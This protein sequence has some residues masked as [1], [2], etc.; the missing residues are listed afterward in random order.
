MGLATRAGA[1][2]AVPSAWLR[3]LP[4]VCASA[5]LLGGLVVTFCGALRLAHSNSAAAAL[6]FQGLA[7]RASDEV[8]HRMGAFEQA[9]RGARGLIVA[10]GPE[11]ITSLVFHQYSETQD[12]TH[13]LPGTIG[14]GVLRRPGRTTPASRDQRYAVQFFEPQV[15]NSEA[16]FGAAVDG[17]L[18]EAAE[19]SMQTGRATLSGPTVGPSGNR[20]PRY[21]MSLIL[22][23][24]GPINVAAEGID[25]SRSNGELRAS[26]WV[27]VPL[28]IDSVLTGLDL[29]AGEISLELRDVTAADAAVLFVSPAGT[30]QAANG[31][32][33]R[34]PLR[35][36]GRTWETFVRAQ[37]PLLAALGQRDP[38]REMTRGI[39]LSAILA[40][41]MWFGVRRNIRRNAESARRV[42]MALAAGAA[43]MHNATLERKVNERTAGLEMAR[44]DLRMILDSMP[45]M[46]SYWDKDLVNVFTNRANEN[47]FGAK[48]GTLRGQHLH[49]LLGEESFARDLPH[50]EAALRGEA[51]SFE[52]SVSKLTGTGF[53]YSVTDYI[54]DVDIGVVRGFYVLTYDVSELVEGRLQLA[55]ALR[56]NEELLRTLDLHAKVSITDEKGFITYVNENFCRILGYRRDEVL[57]RPHSI[58][59]SGVQS[60][61]FWTGMWDTISTGKPWR[62]EICNRSKDGALHWVDAIIAPF[63]GKDGRVQKYV[64]IGTNI[65]ASKAIEHKLRSNEAFL[66]RIG[67][68]AGIGGWEF[69]LETRKVTWSAQM[70]RL[71]EVDPAY[72][73]CSETETA[74]YAIEAQPLI[75]S[76]IAECVE[77]GVAWDFEV[78]AATAKGRPIWVRS[79]GEPEW[80]QGR[81]VRVIG[82]VQDVTARRELTQGIS[83]AESANRA[84]SQ[85]LA[86]MSHEIRTPMNAVMGLSYLLSHTPLTADQSILLAKIQVASNSLLSVITNILDLSKIEANEL[87]VESTVFSVA[88]L[89][90][91]VGIMMEVHA[92]AKDLDFA[93]DIPNDLPEALAG[94]PTRLKQILVNLLSNAIRFTDEGSVRFRT[95]WRANAQAEVILSFSVVDTGIGISPAEQTKI[96]TPFTQ[97]DTSITRRYGGTGL[98]L[99]IVRQLTQLLRGTVEL[100]SIVGIGSTFAVDIPFQLASRGALMALQEAAAV[101]EPGALRGIRVLIVDD[102]AINLEVAKRILELDGALV[103]LAVNGQQAFERLQQDPGAFDVVFMDVQMPILDGY[104]ATRRIRGELGLLNLPIIAVTAGALSSERNRAE[105]A[106]MDDFI[107]KPFSG[108]TLAGSILSHVPAATVRRASHHGENANVPQ[109]TQVPWPEIEGIDAADASVRWCGD[110]SLFITMLARLFDEFGTIRFPRDVEVAGETTQFV[111]QMHK[112]RGG[113]CMLGAKTVH[114]LAGEVEAACLSG[115]FTRAAELSRRVASEIL[116]LGTN[117]RPVIAAERLRAD[118]SLLTATVPVA[119]FLF[120]ELDALL[121]KQS[122]AAVDSFRSLSPQ[123]RQSMG[124]AL[125][126]RMRT[127]ID[128]LQFEEASDLL[129]STQRQPGPM[130]DY[131]AAPMSVAS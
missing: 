111:R 80:Q 69:D 29:G 37:P 12:F 122:L 17:G 40:C 96:F 6:R 74:F 109:V 34:Q 14:I 33:L 118:N 51:R 43:S 107:C 84:K 35:L 116:R 25:H 50:I 62:G 105:D 61:E 38:L 117:A 32:E 44:N 93:M 78:P 52:Q 27:F 79:I 83:K 4:T 67:S 129:E 26:S 85:F 73:P 9:L 60:R 125:Y 99:S 88:D 31:L 127:H 63:L 112:L 53:R 47:W 92:E 21:G 126:E 45:A 54:P 22:P 8:A 97:A 70:H 101:P 65:S 89:L 98:G 49:A 81:V 68:V 23:I 128:N 48:P 15:A 86:N 77:H 108:Q 3:R 131:E 115:D 59:N 100:Q 57:G 28:A 124:H 5:V 114:A 91:D 24:N 36:Y 20:G 106:G 42:A 110:A 46:I 64:S 95:S 11:K 102:C 72:E 120:K 41:L 55:A 19:Q 130:Q 75:E 7:A 90:R 58:L 13:Q 1:I 71:L 113:A 94:D 119:P 18:R 56:E 76:A 87:L 121:R 66:E 39:S 10:V 103:S 2:W 82:A 30:T 104:E 123:L 16:Q